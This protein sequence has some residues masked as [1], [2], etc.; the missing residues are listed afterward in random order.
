MKINNSYIIPF[1]SFLL[2]S[3]G[4]KESKKPDQD[5]TNTVE[6]VRTAKDVQ[7]NQSSLANETPLTKE[8]FASWLPE[9]LL[10]MPLTSST[11]NLLPDIGSCSA[12]Y[13][14][15]NRRIRVMVIDGAGEKGNNA[16]SS[17]RMSSTIEYDEKG[18]WGSTKTTTISDIKVKESSLK[19]GKFNLSMFH[20]NRFAVDVE[21]YEVGHE[22]LEQLV[23]ELNLEQLK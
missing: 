7:E 15:N 23:K 9:T 17:Y 8:E 14:V 19:N 10:G 13:S 11:I 16:V 12:T 1:V 21:T 22:E 5:A 18:T 3:C 20:E 6:L 4:S 2:V